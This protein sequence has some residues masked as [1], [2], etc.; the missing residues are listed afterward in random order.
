MRP[1]NP[2]VIDGESNSVSIT[3]DFFLDRGFFFGVHFYVQTLGTYLHHTVSMV[4]VTD[5]GISGAWLG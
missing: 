2:T 3:G 1:E 5:P 4:G